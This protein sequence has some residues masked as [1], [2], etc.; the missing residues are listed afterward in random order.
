[1]GTNGGALNT[2]ALDYLGERGMRRAGVA[3][4]PGEKAHA[5]RHTY[6]VGQL[7]QGTS[8]AEVQALL[9]HADLSTTGLYLRMS[10][11]ELQQAARAAPVLGLVRDRLDEVSHRVTQQP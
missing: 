5:F 4:R 8:V 9:G 11:A 7:S 6:A 3:L 2:W 10:A 1:M